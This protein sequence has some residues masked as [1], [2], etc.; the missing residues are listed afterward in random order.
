MISPTFN[1]EHGRGAEGQPAPPLITSPGLKKVGVFDHRLSP[2]D[3]SLVTPRY[4]G[5]P[6][7]IECL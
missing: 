5:T 4:G 6:T 2:V 3:S 7:K 1:N